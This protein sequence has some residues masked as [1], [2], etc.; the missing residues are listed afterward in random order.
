MIP[1]KMMERKR[2]AVNNGSAWQAAPLP[3]EAAGA[4]LRAA[5]RA[6]IVSHIRPDGDAIGS[7]LGLGLALQA[8][9]KTA[10]LV[11][12]DG[13][14]GSFRF[15]EGSAVIQRS[16]G[17]LTQYDTVIVV[18]SS[19]LQ[20]T[21]GV[22][23]ERVPDLNI[24][25][26]ITNTGFARV[27]FIDPGQVATAAMIAQ[28]LKVWGFG[29]NKAIAEA[30]LT[31]IV[32]DTIGF[33][34]SNI[35][36]TALRL[37]AELMEQGASLPIVYE[38]ALVSKS[39]EAARYW[40]FG[41][42]KLRQETVRPQGSNAGQENGGARLVWTSL[43]LQDRLGAGYTGNDD[44]DLVNLLSSIEGDVAVIFVEQKNG[45]VKVSWRAVP[46]IDVSKIALQFGGGGHPAAAGADIT[47]DLETVQEKVLGATRAVLTQVEKAENDTR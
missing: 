19:D 39:F 14:P 26:H 10:R 3:V 15:L 43:T 42:S 2:V 45:H 6:L 38:R 28:Y 5:Q 31:G 11:L 47:G 27:N 9:G 1:R 33:R 41:L 20:R 32:T 34:T 16:P 21:G 8:A 7:L 35:T 23:G 29:Y 36:P 40:S 13:L 30:L 46:G 12:V 17:D 44:A 37:A 4:M 18:D 25:H 22:L 24:D